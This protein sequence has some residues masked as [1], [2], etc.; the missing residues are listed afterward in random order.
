MKFIRKHTPGPWRHVEQPSMFRSKSSQSHI[1]FGSDCEHI[2]DHVYEQYDSKLMAQAPSMLNY[3]IER[4]EALYETKDWFSSHRT[5]E[6]AELSR[7]LE[8][9]REVGVEVDE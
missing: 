6:D 5:E 1:E 4:A 8:I 7:L 9:I 2:T 3:L